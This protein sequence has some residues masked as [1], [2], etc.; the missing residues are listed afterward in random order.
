[1]IPPWL[2]VKLDELLPSHT[3][4]ERDAFARAIVSAIPIG[5]I[6]AAVA[7]G[8]GEVFAERGIQDLQHDLSYEIGAAAAEHVSQVLRRMP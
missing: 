3:G 7:R 6:G 2:A 5:A 1:M 8:A 4:A